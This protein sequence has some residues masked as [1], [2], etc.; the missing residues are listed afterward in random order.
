MQGAEFLRMRRTWQYAATT[1]DAVQRRR[2]TFYEAI[3]DGTGGFSMELLE[4]IGSG[5]FERIVVARISIGV[6]FLEALHEVVRREKIKN[7]IILM[8]IGALQKAVFRNVKNFPK[9]F[10]LTPQDRVYF[11]VRKP[12]EIVSLTGYIVPKMN[13]EPHIHAHFSAS[14]VVGETIATYGGHLD[15]GSIT[16][17]KVAVAIGVLEDIAMGKKWVEERKGEDLWVGSKCQMPGHR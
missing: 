9:E 6:D 8:G 5:K 11:E 2:W 14:T 17:V 7:G 1:K 10:P 13:A 15:Q 12:L 4:G 3:K 16:S